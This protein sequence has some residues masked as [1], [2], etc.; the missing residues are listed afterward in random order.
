MVSHGSEPEL[1]LGKKESGAWIDTNST[2]PDTF[3]AGL[4]NMFFSV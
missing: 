3:F 1:V 2:T 4:W